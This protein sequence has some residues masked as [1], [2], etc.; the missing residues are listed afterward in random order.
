MEDFAPFEA[1]FE[2]QMPAFMEVL[3]SR[4]S[5]S[6]LGLD[7]DTF[8][9]ILLGSQF[10]GDVPLKFPDSSGQTPD[11]PTKPPV[12]KEEPETIRKWRE[13]MERQL[14]L[15]DAQEEIKKEELRRTAQKELADWYVRYNEMITKCKNS[16]RNGLTTDWL[17]VRDTPSDRAPEWENIARMC[18]FNAKAMK[19]SKDVSRMRAIIL[20]LK[21]NHGPLG[22]VSPVIS[23]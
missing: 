23:L 22:I 2:T 14:E 21:Q 10:P 19:N 7:D 16:N 17:G 8:E 18:D 9:P 3:L 1:N 12:F 15:K 5:S 20:Q 11:L 4:E 6:G 13:E